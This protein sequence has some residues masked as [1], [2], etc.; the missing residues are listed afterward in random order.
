[1]NINFKRYL[2]PRLD[3]ALS[4]LLVGLMIGMSF[5]SESGS[6]AD[7]AQAKLHNDTHVSVNRSGQLKLEGR[8]ISMDELPRLLKVL[9][10]DGAAVVVLGSDKEVSPEKLTEVLDTIKSAGINVVTVA[11]LQSDAG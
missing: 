3:S 1:M 8:A 6:L 5:N 4:V 10:V 2:P 11:F 7:T 9:N